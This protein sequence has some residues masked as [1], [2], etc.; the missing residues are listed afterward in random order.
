MSSLALF[1]ALGGISYA[2]ATLP[3]NSV[4]TKQL[5]ADAVT[6][7]K[8][9]RGSLQK[10]DF[11]RGVLPKAGVAGPAGAGG[12]KGDKGDPADMGFLD[13]SNDL[14]GLSVVQLSIDA[15]SLGN[16]KGYRVDCPPAKLCTVTIGGPQ[17][18]NI[19][20]Q[21]WFELAMLGDPAAVKSFSITERSTVDGIPLRRYHVSN[22]KPISMRQQNG[23]FEITFST[24]F[25]QRVAI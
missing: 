3:K 2:A 16:Y 5:K 20:M 18:A 6:G 15:Y 24:E 7:A 1:I 4:G 10:S 9:K 8:I 12:A 21:A 13:P 22:G 17:N 11:A 25:V 14:P 19:E 23:R